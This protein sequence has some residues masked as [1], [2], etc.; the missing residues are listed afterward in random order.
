MAL[1]L[2]K[3]IG[4]Y[5]VCINKCCTGRLLACAAGWGGGAA[6]SYSCLLRVEIQMWLDKCVLSKSKN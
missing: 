3:L 5:C 4:N 2:R 1:A 6:S